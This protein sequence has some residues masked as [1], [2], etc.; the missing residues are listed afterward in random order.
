[1]EPSMSLFTRTQ[2]ISFILRLWPFAFCPSSL[3][4]DVKYYFPLQ[5]EVNNTFIKYI[6]EINIL[7]W[8]KFFKKIFNLVFLNPYIWIYVFFVKLQEVT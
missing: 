2:T 5:N 4:K 3:E 8:Q 6:Y 1:M 7:T